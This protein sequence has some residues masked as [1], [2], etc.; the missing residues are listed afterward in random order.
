MSAGTQGWHFG[1]R[2]EAGSKTAPSCNQQVFWVLPCFSFLIQ[3]PQ[4]E[5]LSAA[6]QKAARFWPL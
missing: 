3:H 5:V 4:P 2:A 6:G 1:K